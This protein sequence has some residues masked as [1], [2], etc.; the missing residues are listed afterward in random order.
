MISDAASIVPSRSGP[1]RE[2]CGLSPSPGRTLVAACR[3]LS[4][5]PLHGTVFYRDEIELL[6]S[7]TLDIWHLRRRVIRMLRMGRILRIGRC[8]GRAPTGRVLSFLLS[9]RRG[10]FGG[11]QLPERQFPKN[12]SPGVT[13]RGRQEELSRTIRQNPKHPYNPP[14]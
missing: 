14:S 9:R 8:G 11:L 3:R 1:V 12:P 6:N 10:P 4:W 13:R 5:F 2:L 7:T